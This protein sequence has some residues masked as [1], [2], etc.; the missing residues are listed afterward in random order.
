MFDLTY[1]LAR[2]RPLFF[3]TVTTF[4]FLAAAD[5]RTVGVLASEMPSILAFW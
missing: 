1:L 4:A 2:L 3:G 5:R